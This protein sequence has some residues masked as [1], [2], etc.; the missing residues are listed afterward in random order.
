MSGPEPAPTPPDHSTPGSVRPFARGRPVTGEGRE[1]DLV[2]ERL[3]FFSGAIQESFVVNRR[4][5]G[6]AGG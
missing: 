5:D 2:L 4:W 3:L 6:H 1:R